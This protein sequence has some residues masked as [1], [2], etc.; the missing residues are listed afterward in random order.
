MLLGQAW[1]DP[2]TMP[3]DDNL[4]LLILEDCLVS[5]SIPLAEL[6]DGKRTLYCVTKINRLLTSVNHFK[7]TNNYRRKAA[8]ER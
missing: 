2:V 7:G 6:R 4:I 1:Y 8:N 3:F 5:G